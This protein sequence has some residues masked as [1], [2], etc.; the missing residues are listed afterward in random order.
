MN[1]RVH[2]LLSKQHKKLLDEI[3]EFHGINTSNVIRMLLVDEHRRIKKEIN[4]VAR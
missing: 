2:M 3:S 4:R 1:H